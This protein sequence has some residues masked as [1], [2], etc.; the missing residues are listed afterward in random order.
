MLC[1]P[2]DATVA[3]DIPGSKDAL[4]QACKASW[5]INRRDGPWDASSKSAKRR[6]HLKARFGVTFDFY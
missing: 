5:N 1:L 3:A 6:T 4:H 2:V